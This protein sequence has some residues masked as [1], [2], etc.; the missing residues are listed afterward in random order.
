MINKSNFITCFTFAFASQ[1]RSFKTL[2]VAIT[3]SVCR[4]RFSVHKK[5][6]VGDAAAIIIII[7]IIITV[8]IIIILIIIAIFYHYNYLCNDDSDNDNFRNNNDN[9]NNFNDNVILIFTLN[10][11]RGSSGRNYTWCLFLACKQYLR[12]RLVCR[13][14]QQGAIR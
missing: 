14:T 8:I 2:P 3:A 4:V 1:T 6:R 11:G 9:N 5:K 12:T 10:F 7:I 13:M